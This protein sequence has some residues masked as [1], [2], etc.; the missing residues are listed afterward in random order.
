PRQTGHQMA[1]HHGSAGHPVSDAA[2]RA[3]RQDAVPFADLPNAV[4]PIKQPSGQRRARPTKLHARKA[5][6][7]PHCRQALT[8]R[9][10]RI[11]RKELKRRRT[12]A[13]IAGPWSG[14]W[15]GSINTGG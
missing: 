12:W 14:P 11:T 3:N 4:S 15:R 7:I 6:D 8:R 2:D 5:Y 13:G 1:C 10:I 9:Y